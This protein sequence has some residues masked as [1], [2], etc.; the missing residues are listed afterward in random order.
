MSD[1]IRI[2]LRFFSDQANSEIYEVL[3]SMPMRRRSSYLRGL[4]EKAFYGNAHP[5]GGNSRAGGP[6][7]VQPKHTAHA[8]AKPIKTATA[9]NGGSARKSAARD[10]SAFGGFGEA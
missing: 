8:P 10:Y 2:N 7:I 6:A 9:M 1:P 5:S 3:Q 4:I